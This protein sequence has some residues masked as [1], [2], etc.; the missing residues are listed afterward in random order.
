MKTTMNKLYML[1]M[2]ICLCGCQTEVMIRIE[3]RSDVELKGVI[4]QFPSQTEN[5]GDILPGQATEYREIDKAYGYAYVEAWINGD[6][7]VLQPEDY[8]GEKLLSGG[9][10]TYVLRHN[11]EATEKWNRLRLVMEKK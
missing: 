2:A 3:N 11:N 7:A 6:E 1:V 10:Y 4:V 8:V 9:N 5:Y